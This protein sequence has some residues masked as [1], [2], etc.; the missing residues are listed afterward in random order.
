M[1]KQVRDYF[2]NFVAFSE[3][4]NFNELEVKLF[5]LG[6]LSLF[7]STF[8]NP[9]KLR[10]SEK[11]TKIERNRPLFFDVIVLQ[12]KRVIRQM[13][14]AFSEYINFTTNFELLAIFNALP[15]EKKCF[16]CQKK[17]EYIQVLRP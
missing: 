9:I 4:L 7:L 17:Y 13:F 8:P 11:A 5:T 10:F 1:S 3:C 2:L 12:K 16:R 15:E 6:D 14:V